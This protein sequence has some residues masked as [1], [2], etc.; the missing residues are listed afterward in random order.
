MAKPALLPLLSL[1]LAAAGTA[2]SPPASEAHSMSALQKTLADRGRNWLP[3]LSRHS[4]SL[5]VYKL[6]AGAVDGQSPHDMDEV[7]YVV[8]GKAVLQAGDQRHDA[9]KGAVLFVA[10]GQPHR[11]VD[12]EEDLTTLVFFSTQRAATGGMA[13]GPKPVE[14]TPYHE[15]SERGNTRIFYWYQASSAGNVSID[16]GQPR[17]KAQY[18][19]FL[20]K[21][22]GKRWRFGQNFW[23]SLDTNIPLTIGGVELDV[24]QYYL[25]LENH[26]EHG[27]RLIALDPQAVRQQRLDAYE[28]NKTKGGIAL[29]L[30]HSKTKHTAQSLSI[31][32]TVD[33][34]EKHR[35]DLVVHFG[36]H[37]LTARVAMKP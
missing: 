17:W 21:P 19:P 10:A 27:L 35:A 1:L 16:Y 7:Y 37:R 26:S 9:S 4:M 24:G 20:T 30:E 18:E 5:G 29:P 23:T 25:V 22:S 28:A 33:R 8:S 15:G 31:E 34:S 14:Q 32:L 3:V 36:P 2:Q 6:A 12:I 11:F 13:T